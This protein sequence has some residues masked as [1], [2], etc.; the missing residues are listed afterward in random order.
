MA[1]RLAL[2]SGKA[3]KHGWHPFDAE[4]GLEVRQAT[5]RLRRNR[6]EVRDRSGTVVR[7]GDA[8]FDRLRSDPGWLP[9]GL[10]G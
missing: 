9:E 3:S 6:W 8:E 5:G 2:T 1:W 4:R 7:L 10:G